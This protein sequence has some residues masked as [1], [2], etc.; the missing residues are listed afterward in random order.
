MHVSSC[1]I[2]I[3]LPKHTPNMNM[4]NSSYFTMQAINVT[5]MFIVMFVPIL[6]TVKQIN[7]QDNV[8]E[9]SIRSRVSGRNRAFPRHRESY[10]F[11]YL[12]EDKKSKGQL[13]RTC[14][15]KVKVI[16]VQYRY[17]IASRFLVSHISTSEA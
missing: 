13:F 11:D 17:L 10:R 7:C 12:A 4:K 5:F 14:R 2:F 15:K 1:L 3:N 8:F 16:L 6:T 9:T